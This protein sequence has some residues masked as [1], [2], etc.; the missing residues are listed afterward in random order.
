MSVNVDQRWAKIKIKKNI[1]CIRQSTAVRDKD[2]DQ[3][4]PQT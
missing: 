2:I 1:I 4:V 3:N